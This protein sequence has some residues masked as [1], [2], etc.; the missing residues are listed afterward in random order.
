MNDI[1]SAVANVLKEPAPASPRVVQARFQELV[2]QRDSALN[3]AIQHA[4]RIAEL[5][6]LVQHQQAE[7]VRL[8]LPPPPPD[9]PSREPPQSHM[10]SLAPPGGNT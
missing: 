1:A 9:P 5:E 3:V 10:D 4:G 6:E 2:N 7:I 8:R